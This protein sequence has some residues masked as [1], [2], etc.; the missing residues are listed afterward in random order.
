MKKGTR[1]Y[2]NIT[3]RCN[4]NCPFC[5]MYSSTENDTFMSFETFKGIIDS[6][7]GPFELQLEGGEPTIHPNLYLFIEYA[8]STNRCSKVIILTNGITLNTHLKRMVDL[9]HWY[10]IPFEIKVS[11]NYWLISQDKEH[12]R[13][14]SDYVFCTEFIPEFN[15]TI[16]TRK[17]ETDGWIDEEINKYSNLVDINR[18][19]FFQSY[20]KLTDSKYDKPVIV[21]NIDNWKI[22]S[23]DGKCFDQ[24]L[25]ARSEYENQLRTKSNV[26]LF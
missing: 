22:Y 11:V 25:I 12:I 4:T 24:D 5:C 10:D 14:I 9:H 26:T 13:K 18:S 6:C 2:I 23:C 17:R 1:L 16:N 19:F 20:G 21:Q 15:I 3:N 8:I 7:E